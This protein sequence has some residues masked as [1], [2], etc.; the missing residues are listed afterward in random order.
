[1]PKKKKTDPVQLSLKPSRGNERLVRKALRRLSSNTID[2]GRV[3]LSSVTS[4]GAAPVQD[5]PNSSTPSQ[6]RKSETTPVQTTNVLAERLARLMAGQN[7]TEQG[8]TANRR[9]R[10]KRRTASMKSEKRDTTLSPVIL[11][12][13]IRRVKSGAALCA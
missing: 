1:M 9:E 13:G 7:T 11:T 12:T 4:T 3:S 2:A 10:I 8:T 6:E 5:A